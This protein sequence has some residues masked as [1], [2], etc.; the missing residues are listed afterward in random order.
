MTHDNVVKLDRMARELEVHY[1]SPP[2]SSLGWP[3]CRFV[4]GVVSEAS[5]PVNLEVVTGTLTM[6]KDLPA[7]HELRCDVDMAAEHKIVIMVDDVLNSSRT[8]IHAFDSSWRPPAR[9]TAVLVDRK[10]RSF[11]I[12]LLR[13]DAEHPPQR[14]HRSTCPTRPRVGA[15]GAPRALSQLPSSLQRTCARASSSKASVHS[16]CV[17]VTSA[18][19]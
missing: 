6:H 13:F 7:G 19:P 2:S 1:Q 11:P 9:F 10:H 18:W 4:R 3:R 8:L 16:P 5:S 17:Q 15:F 12:Q 14:T